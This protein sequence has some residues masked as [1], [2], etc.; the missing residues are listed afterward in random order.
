[1]GEGVEARAEKH[2][3][4]ESASD[5]FGQVVLRIAAARGKRGAEGAGDRMFLA[6]SVD[7]EA[8]TKNRYGYGVSQDGRVV[9]KLVSG[10]AGGDTESC[11]AG[12]AGL[13]EFEC[14]ARPI[15]VKLGNL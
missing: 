11:F 1:M 12:L 8:R 5:C 10:A 4:S 2:V 7:F 13:H 9:E 15:S 3:L 14:K 6:F